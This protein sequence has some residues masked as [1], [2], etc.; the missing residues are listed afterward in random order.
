MLN[1]PSF[2][3]NEVPMTSPLHFLI[4]YLWPRWEES[5]KTMTWVILK[6]LLECRNIFISQ[7]NKQNMEK[8]W[9]KIEQFTNNSAGDSECCSPRK[10]TSQAL[11][12][13]P[14]PV[15]TNLSITLQGALFLLSVSLCLIRFFYYTSGNI[16]WEFWV[17]NTRTSRRD[18][19]SPASKVPKV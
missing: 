8:C 16:S 15:C 11:Q 9:G 6:N 4:C 1:V 12:C 7:Q 5:T 2:S 10:K 19:D 13:I 18:K 14:G 17:L 3:S